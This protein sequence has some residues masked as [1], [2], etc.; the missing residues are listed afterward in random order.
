MNSDYLKHLGDTFLLNE[1]YIYISQFGDLN[2]LVFVNQL[3]R[4]S[5]SL[6]SFI[7]LIIDRYI[8]RLRELELEN[9]IDEQE[10]V[11]QRNKRFQT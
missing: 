2:D 8:S 11:V 10:L 5:S 7:D 4:S 9:F 6:F 3:N 1:D